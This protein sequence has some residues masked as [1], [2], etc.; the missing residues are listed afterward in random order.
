MI[1]HN[2]RIMNELINGRIECEQCLS[3]H[4]HLTAVTH[5]TDPSDITHRIEKK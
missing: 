5:E 4:A 2:D 3:V 1:E